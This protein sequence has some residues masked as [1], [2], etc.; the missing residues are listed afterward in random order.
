MLITAVGRDFLQLLGLMSVMIIQDPI[1]S[2]A[3]LV[4]APPAILML[5]KLVRRIKSI[6]RSQFSGGARMLETMQEAILGIRIVKAFALEE[7]MQRRLEASV[8]ALEHDSDK[9]ARLANRSGPVMETLG[10]IAVALAVVY[11]GYRTIVATATPGEF[12]SFIAAFLLAYEPA[13][14]LARFEYRT[15]QWARW[16]SPAV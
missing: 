6:A 8:L 16:R 3:S 7:E 9:M 1:M 15:E 10:G 5:R 4:L 2:F 13:K 11:G 12:F 14:R